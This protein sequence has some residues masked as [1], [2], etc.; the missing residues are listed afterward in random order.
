M[1][2]NLKKPCIECPFRKA[3]TRGWL[4]GETVKDTYDQV[5][6]EGPFACHMTRHKRAR[7]MSRCRGS[8]L[9][10]KKSCKLPKY[11]LK[12]KKEL[13]VISHTDPHMNQ[14]LSNQEFHS[15]HSP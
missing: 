12:L 8:L 15:Y 13:E 5:M 1:K 10:M 14:I 9:F 2:F 3:S 4:G 7:D 11:D 6:G